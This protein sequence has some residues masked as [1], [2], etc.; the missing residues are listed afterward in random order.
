MALALFSP[1]FA[2]GGN[3]P[4][5]FTCHGEDVPPPLTWTGVPHRT[6]SF[7]LIVDDPDAANGT[8][9]HWILF[10]IAANR[11][12][13]PSQPPLQ[14]VGVSGTNSRG[15]L[16]YMGP[17]PP[18]GIHRYVFR[19]FALGVPTLGLSPG[20]SREQVENRMAAHTLATA[21]LIGRYGQ[22][23]SAPS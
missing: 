4:D 5:R 16:G 19:L 7:S 22:R 21:D 17:C 6:Q 11:N 18:S 10:D 9:T 14:A 2:P 3:I 12:D 8:F 1:A 23:L 20:A 15:E 13:L